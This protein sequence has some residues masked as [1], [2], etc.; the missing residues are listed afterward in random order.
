LCIMICGLFLAACQANSDVPWATVAPTRAGGKDTPKRTLPTVENPLVLPTTAFTAS[1][2]LAPKGQVVEFWHPWQGDLAKRVD[3]AVAEFNQTNE[4]NITVKVKPFYSSG[5]LDEA[6]SAG[7]KDKANGLPPLVAAASDQLAAWSALNDAVVGLDDFLADPQYGMTGAEMAAFYPAFWAQDQ[8][9]GRRIGIPALRTARV[10]F[11]NESWAKDLGFSGPPKTPAEFKAQACAAAKKNNTA[12]IREKYGT[13]GWMIDN[14]ALT[15][16]SWLGVFGAQ[17]IPAED[18]KPY[19]FQS[20]E[21]QDA[22]SF[23]RG[24]LD[25]GCAWLARNPAPYEYFA[26]RMALF[27]SGTLPDVYIQS[28]WQEKLKNKDTWQILPFLGKD[29]K[30]VVYSSGY[31]YAVFQSTPETELAAW[32]FIRWLEKPAVAAKFETALPSLPVS[33][34]H[35]VQFSESK[36]QFPWNMILPLIESARPAPVLP[37]WLEAHRLVED[38]AW[39]TYRVPVGD[40][41]QILPQLD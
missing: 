11:Y 29:G 14:D 28:R 3:E 25:E 33:S 20:K 8:V 15:T 17:P 26:R 13:G 30:P 18:G 31:S 34:A 16:L 4:W 9:G 40:L 6:I 5:A 32:I 41:P 24:M 21:A 19:T 27:Y 12:G 37:S 2:K 10:I 39:Q 36:G 22:L 35:A 1:P 38:A 7:L 23:L